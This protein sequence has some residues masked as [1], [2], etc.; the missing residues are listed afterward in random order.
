[1]SFVHLHLHSQYSLLDGAITAEGMLERAKAT[2][3]PAVALTDHGN[4]HGALEFYQ[5]AIK[6]EVQPIIGIEGYITQGDR[7]DKSTQFPT[8]H[9]V[10]L[11][12]SEEGVR[13][14]Y[15]LVTLANFE[16]YYYKPRMDREI[17]R[18]YSKGLIGLSACLNGV[19]ARALQDHRE[20]VA[21]AAIRE[22]RDIFG[23][24]NYYLELM[25]T[26]MAEQKLVNK[27]LI[28]LSKKLS[29][30]LV[31]TND[32]H[33]LNKEDAQ[34][35]DALLCIGTGKLVADQDRMKF[36]SASY[37]MKSPDEMRELFA[38]CPEAIANTL[39]IA[40]KCDF[41][42][43]L[44][45]YHMPRYTLPEGKSLD[46]ELTDLAKR[47]LEERMPQILEF[48]RREGKPTEKISDAYLERLDRELKTIRQTGFSGYF[49]IVQDFIN[50]AK[51]K[52]IPVGPGRGSAAGSLVAFATKI[53]DIDPIPY[54]LLF[55][56]FLNPERVSLPDI[57]VDF[58]QDGRDEVI[59]YVAQKYGGS[60]SLEETKVAQITTFGKM[61]ARAVI[62]DVGRVLN[63]PY[64]EV[65]RIAKLVPAVLNITLQDAFEQEPKFEEL[66]KKDARIDELLNIALSLEGLTRHASVHAAGV[67][68][69]DDRPLVD[70]LPLYKGQHDEVVTQWDMKGVEKVGLIKF[71]FLGLKTLTLLARAVKLIEATHAVKIDLHN[72]NMSDAKVYEMLSNAD[73]QGVFQLESSGMR[74]LVAKLKPSQ[75]EDL[76][77]LVALYRPG[78]LGSGMVDDFINRKHGRTAIVY[79][80][81]Q[82]EPILKDTY[83]V[84]LYQEQVMQIASTLASYSLGEADLLRRAMGKKIPEEM[85]KQAERFL[86]GC[87]K[88]QIPEAKA[89]RIFELMEKFAGYGFNKSHSAA[90]A[91]ISFQTAY[92]KAHY[93]VE[94]MAACFSIDRDNTDRVVLLMADCRERGIEVLPPDVN[95][96]DL[97]FSVV[98]G[99]IR[100]GLAGVKNVGEASIHAILDARSASGVFKSL[101]DFCS[102]VDLRKVNK[103]VIESLIK[104]GAFD[105]TSVGRSVLTASLEKAMEAAQSTQR[106][107]AVGQTSLFGGGGFSTPEFKFESVP[108]WDEGTRLKFEKESVG[109]FISGHPLLRYTD[110]LRRYANA[111]TNRLSE[112]KDQSTARIGGMV[113]T[114]K[115]ITTKKGDRMAFVT[116]EDLVGRVEVVAFSDLYREKSE[117]LKGEEPIFL[118]GKVDLGEDQ[119]KL[120]ATEVAP[121]EQAHTLFTGTVHIEVDATHIDESKLKELRSTLTRF[122]GACPA[123]LHLKIPGKSET[124]LALPR[125]FGVLPS[126]ELIRE[127]TSILGSTTE[128]HFS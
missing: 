24:E 61:Q 10:L 45:E 16:G 29:V 110:I 105:S 15:R 121:L 55:E 116:I 39:E 37:Y 22:Y 43:K 107:R 33:Y 96:S 83:G 111:D 102:R 94:F 35:H 47:G 6:A 98:E 64:G 42:M 48:Y 84:I 63:M 36:N 58:C 103:R 127:V 128:V 118:V 72:L 69:S 120:I 8:N 78:P 31:A 14:L 32:C 1:M 2:G 123:V 17:L 25:D 81:P 115:E 108:D 27:G 86:D 119:P 85:A 56:R 30:P 52:G 93:P 65:D 41:R 57:D 104:C 124:V 88:N 70:H 9:I 109:F 92:L 23:D 38:D 4:L 34:A 28:E 49:L 60:T 54:N 12:Q 21:E 40:K 26:G 82:L 19:P 44:G 126:G 89:K 91:L 97:D 11:A 46:D 100:F 67:V 3:M 50:E 112:L 90:Y 75:F 114:L 7:R 74:D 13:N 79:D 20:D 76:I 5:A 53:T 117:I 99:K 68:I 87:R 80:V 62:R 95:V 106:D 122:K 51:S 59:R 77:A 71:D 125:N 66:R 18:K 113:S 73:T 101:F